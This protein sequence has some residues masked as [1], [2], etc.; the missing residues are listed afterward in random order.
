MEKYS[1]L[2]R[3]GD[4]ITLDGLCLDDKYTNLAQLGDKFVVQAPLDN[5]RYYVFKSFDAFKI[6]LNACE[7]SR[8]CY[9]EVIFGFKEQK[10]KIDIDSETWEGTLAEFDPILDR[11][12]VGIE[13]TFAVMWGVSLKP[14]D[15]VVTNSSGNG[16][17]SI[18][19][20]VDNYYLS[21]HEDALAVSR[22]LRN[23]LDPSTGIY[24]DWAVYK[25]T[26]NFRLTDSIKEGT[27]RVKKIISTGENGPHTINNA[28]I[29]YIP[30]CYGLERRT[31]RVIDEINTIEYNGETVNAAVQLA[32]EYLDGC[33]LSKPK[34][35]W[36]FFNRTEPGHCHICNRVHENENS[37]MLN[38]YKPN[39]DDKIIV[40]FR[41]IRDGAKQKIKVGELKVEKGNHIGEVSENDRIAPGAPEQSEVPK[42][43]SKLERILENPQMPDYPELPD[44]NK[45][46]SPEIANFE[47]AET[48][49]VRAAM[50]M[51]KT[52]RLKAYIDTHYA[53]TLMNNKIIFISF[54][55]TFSANIK[56]KFDDFTLYSQVQGP[57]D[58]NRLIVQVESL[59]RIPVSDEFECPELIILDESESIFEQ[60]GSGLGR[61][62]SQSWS[63]FEWLVKYAD[64]VICMDAHLGSRTINLMNTLRP[65]KQTK[66]HWNT[67]KN[68][69]RDKYFFTDNLGLF[70][71]NLTEDVI[72]GYKVV[73]P[74]NSLKLSE[75]I[76]TMMIEDF[77]NKSVGIF[78]SL[79]ENADKHRTFANVDEAW[80]VFDV[81]IYTPTVS[82]GVSFE[83]NHYD[84][85]YG[86]FT[87]MS[88][89]V[90]TCMQMLMRVRNLRQKELTIYFRCLGNNLPVTTESIKNY[91]YLNREYTIDVKMLENVPRV[92]DAQGRLE[93]YITPYFNVWLENTRINN[94]S[95]NDFIQRMLAYVNSIGAKLHV[96]DDED[97]DEIR[98]SEE[99]FACCVKTA[100]AAMEVAIAESIDLSPDAAREYEDRLQRASG[101]ETINITRAERMQYEKY[102]LRKYYRVGGNNI[103]PEFV[104]KY[105]HS[106]VKL[107]YMALTDIMQTDNLSTSLRCIKVQESSNIL[108]SQVDKTRQ[109]YEI[110]RR[111]YYEVHDFCVKMLKWSGLNKMPDTPSWVNVGTLYDELKRDNV[112]KSTQE[113]LDRCLVLLGLRRP[114]LRLMTGRLPPEN[115]PQMVR[116]HILS[117]VKSANVITGAFYGILWKLRDPKNPESDIFKIVIGSFA[118][119]RFQDRPSVGECYKPSVL[120]LVDNA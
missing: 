116:A 92:Y 39:N 94:L 55:Q 40:F 1:K 77:P 96:L 107:R 7:T 45:Y 119:F 68:A 30:Y 23:L 32:Y 5:R 33:T 38:L 67:H 120:S 47:I 24:I 36:I 70:I 65:N 112:Y 35:N 50:K 34:G 87:D 62:A 54:R 43:K 73:I 13:N 59:H 26:Q 6:Y 106:H 12:K 14:T 16:K 99:K 3:K 27:N 15:F 53:D 82:A 17:L 9:H 29:T 104:G 85:I 113:Q 8:K 105:N 51:G 78:N 31:A 88:C 48:L 28:T 101:D 44:M 4:S 80:S 60:F 97:L 21:G 90:E 108:S 19:I 81:L 63:V 114:N 58:Q 98:Q 83:R 103:T 20:I 49:L 42:K 115:K 76:Y 84:S 52:K 117:F 74:T 56:Q 109:Y 69:S 18:H 111:Y 91:L 110:S 10:F 11:I 86:M 25:R 93:Y 102:K 118:E 71:F 89:S 57:L 72:R 64:R 22:F 75:A 66:L 100:N 37:A 46:D 61:S 79:S 41:C 95:R 2:Y